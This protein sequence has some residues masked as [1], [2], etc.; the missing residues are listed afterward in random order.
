MMQGFRAHTQPV[1]SSAIQ[2]LMEK[3]SNRHKLLE[4]ELGIESFLKLDVL[5][6]R[7]N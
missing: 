2:E 5:Y 1:Q 6:H 4:S 7:L 3:T